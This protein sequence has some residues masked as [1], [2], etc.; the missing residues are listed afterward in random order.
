MGASKKVA[1]IAKT[2][3]GKIKHRKI[4]ETRISVAFGKLHQQKGE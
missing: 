4:R 2:V 1:A 3:R